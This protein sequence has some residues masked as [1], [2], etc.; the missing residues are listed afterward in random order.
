MQ[1]PS[2][3][4]K[5]II[6]KI[7]DKRGSA[8]IPILFV[9]TFFVALIFF[10]ID[11]TNRSTQNQ[12]I[13]DTIRECLLSTGADNL[14]TS[15]QPTRDSKLGSFVY[16][17]TT[18]S[19]VVDTSLFIKRLSN[20][21]NSIVTGNEISSTDSNGLLNFSI[22]DIKIYADNKNATYIVDYGLTIPRKSF[23]YKLHTYKQ[24]Q[25]VSYKTAF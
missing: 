3:L 11:T 22:S 20:D 18:F 7:T 10:N 19:E 21:F 6:N 5:N 8:V 25:I 4:L 12:Y 13:T 24:R 2:A 16:N 9:F 17:G 1:K 15:Y 14:L 23:G